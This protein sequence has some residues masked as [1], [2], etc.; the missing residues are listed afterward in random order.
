MEQR[1]EEHADAGAEAKRTRPQP[2]V[3]E[4]H[5]AQNIVI[6]L[7]IGLTGASIGVRIIQDVH[8]G[9]TAVLFVGLPAILAIAVVLTPPARTATGVILKTATIVMLL[10]GILLGETL[11]CMLIASPL[12]YLVGFAIGAPID[13]ARRAKARGQ[14]GARYHVIIAAVLLAGLEGAVPGL[15]VPRHAEVTVTRH[16]D[17]SPAQVRAALAR[18]PDFDRRRPPLLRIGFPQPIG[19]AGAGLAVGDRRMV[20]IRG[21]GHH[22][23][24][25][26]G[27]LVMDVTASTPGGVTFTTVEDTSRIADWLTWNESVVTWEADGTGTR[28]S[29]TLRYERE[30]APSW[31]FGPV[32]R[33]AVHL[34]AGYLIDALATP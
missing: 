19:A 17:A 11:I 1:A 29:W 22:G 24:T 20:V 23:T 2:T 18:R 12:V 34:T 13:R 26:T 7:A 8:L 30:L 28:V 31:Y 16:I 25:V 33:G 14:S 9:Q 10:A 3:R 4:Q 27:R 32:Q 5:R 15:D 21:A 6:A